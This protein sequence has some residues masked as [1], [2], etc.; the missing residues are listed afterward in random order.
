MKELIE[1][2]RN[3]DAITKMYPQVSGVNKDTK[4]VYAEAADAI[5]KL[6]AMNDE[7]EY[8]LAGVMHSVDK[9]LEADDFEHDEVQRAAI[10]R[11]KVLQIIENKQAKIKELKTENAKLRKESDAAVACLEIVEEQFD[12]GACHNDYAEQA[13]AEWR[14]V[15]EGDNHENI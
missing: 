13:I 2:L 6:Q 7:L 5:E 14:G 4:T 11:E 15:Q 12:R 10:M 1:R 9:W 3:Y 8:T